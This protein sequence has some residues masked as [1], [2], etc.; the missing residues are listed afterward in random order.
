MKKIK[1][2]DAVG[3]VLCHDL[4]QIIPGVTKDARFRKGHIIEKD[5][6]EVL[7]SMGKRHL[8]VYEINE[9]M[10]H[11]NDAA[12]VLRDLCI[13]KYMKETEIKEGK[14]EVE[15]EINGFLQVDRERLKKINMQDEIIIATIKDGDIRQGQRIAG[16]RVIPL[17]IDKKKLEMAKSIVGERPL[18]EIHPYKVKTFGMVVTGSE[19][20]NKIIEDKFSPVVENKLSKYGVKLVKKIYCDDDRDMIMGAISE[21]K[22]MGVE[23]ICCLGGMS[24][25]PDDMTPSA[26]ISSDVEVVTYGV[27]TLPGAMLLIGYFAD[28]TPVVGL[29][30]CVMYASATIFDVVLP[31]LLAKVKLTKEEIAELGYGGYCMHCDKCHFPNCAFG[32]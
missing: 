10:L 4:T 28:G 30:G 27:P 32:K 19:V 9:D 24:V 21:L 5:D 13:N 25:D 18:L 16:M 11:E 23:M 31:R 17:V 22:G 14:I 3:T 12:L 2:E 7:R 1:V 8:F 29:P 20:Y 26:I 15:S 6:I